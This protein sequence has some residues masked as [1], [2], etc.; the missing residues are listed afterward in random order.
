VRD[1]LGLAVPVVI[2]FLGQVNHLLEVGADGHVD[3]VATHDVLDAAD[4]VFDHG[5]LWLR[6]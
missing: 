2:G 6:G 5:C 4:G 1:A 3:G